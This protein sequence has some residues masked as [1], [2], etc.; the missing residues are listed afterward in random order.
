MSW[1]GGCGWVRVVVVITLG[2]GGP[3]GLCVGGMVWSIDVTD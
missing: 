2:C 3:T 1:A